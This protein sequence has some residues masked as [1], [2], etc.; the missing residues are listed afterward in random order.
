MFCMSSKVINIKRSSR[1]W[2]GHAGLQANW[3]SRNYWR[4]STGNLTWSRRTHC[5]KD[6]CNGGSCN[7]TASNHLVWETGF[8]SGVLHYAK[9]PF[10][11]FFFDKK[12][13][14]WASLQQFL[15]VKR[16]YQKTSVF[17][18]YMTS[19]YQNTLQN[20]L[21]MGNSK[22]LFESA[23]QRDNSTPTVQKY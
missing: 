15:V 20:T 1:C 11:F 17:T 8:P 5:C 23:K 7:H 18:L 9:M 21:L 16:R 10:L 2:S 14:L 13:C 22:C 6:S 4:N 19:C 12:F 3:V